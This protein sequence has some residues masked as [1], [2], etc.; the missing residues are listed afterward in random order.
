[1]NRIM[2]TLQFKTTCLTFS[3]LFLTCIFSQTL[4]ETDYQQYIILNRESKDVCLQ[5]LLDERDALLK[6]TTSNLQNCIDMKDAFNEKPCYVRSDIA[7]GKPS[8]QSSTFNKFI[9]KYA[10]DGNRGTDLIEDMCSHTAGGDTNPWWMVDLQAV[11]Y[12]KTVRIFNRGMDK[13][14]IDVSHK[15]QNVTVTVG[16][17]E[18]AINTLCGFFPGPGT[19]SQIVVIDCPTSPIGKFVK[20]SKTTPG[21]TICEV[22]VFGN[23]L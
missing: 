3:L 10:V 16:E 23:L 1:M 2:N 9:A 17:T 5:S 7:L 8:K 19:L 6:E 21:L 18:S 22:D 15:L 14:G 4:Y 12:I 11:Y 13:F 20:I